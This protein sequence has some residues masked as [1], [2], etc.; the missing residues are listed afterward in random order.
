MRYGVQSERGIVWYGS[1]REGGRLLRQYTT[2]C[3]YIYFMLWG[4]REGL[5]Q[6]H[7]AC[8]CACMPGP[9]CGWQAVRKYDTHTYIHSTRKMQCGV[10]YIEIADLASSVKI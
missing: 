10:H 3:V 1:V 7:T 4:G 5:R 6:Q 8:T 2:H 9:C